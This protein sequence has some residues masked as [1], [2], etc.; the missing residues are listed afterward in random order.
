MKNHNR[1]ESIKGQVRDKTMCEI[2]TKK[3]RLSNKREELIPM[4]NST[5]SDPLHNVN[6]EDSRKCDVQATTIVEKSERF[7]PYKKLPITSCSTEVSIRPANQIIKC[8]TE[9]S[10]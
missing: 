3:M 10:T 2:I 8:K 9:S 6:M 5:L 4:S 7:E 1:S